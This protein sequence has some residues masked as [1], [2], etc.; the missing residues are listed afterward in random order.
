MK[1]SLFKILFFVSL[2]F[3]F[4]NSQMQMMPVPD[5]DAEIDPANLTPDPF[6]L[7]QFKKFVD[8]IVL[9]LTPKS[10]NEVMLNFPHLVILFQVS[11]NPEIFEGYEK[12]AKH[13]KKKYKVI[14]AVYTMTSE[15]DEIVQKFH[16]KEYPQIYF[17]DKTKKY[18]YSGD[19]KNLTEIRSFIADF[20]YREIIELKTQSDFLSFQNKPNKTK[21]LAVYEPKM[22]KEKKLLAEM[23]S[24]DLF[25][26][27]GPFIIGWTTDQSIIPYPSNVE[28]PSL[29]LYNNFTD[30]EG[31]KIAKYEGDYYDGQEI[32]AF[33]EL[34][35]LP[36]VSIYN[37][38]NS[39]RIFAGPVDVQILL[40]LNKE[41]DHSKEIEE[42]K[43][44][45]RYNKEEE[46]HFER[47]IFTI[48]YFEEE[49]LDFLDFFGIEKSEDLATSKIF[50]TK[51]D[52]QL[53]RMD[54][55]LFEKDEIIQENLKDFIEDFRTKQVKRFYKSDP[56]VDN[57]NNWPLILV[58]SEFVKEVIRSRDNYVVLFCSE[59]EKKQCKGA[60][61]FFEKLAERITLE[62]RNKVKFAYFDMGRNEVC[63]K[64]Y[65]EKLIFSNRQMD[66]KSKVFHI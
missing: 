8:P 6:K 11:Q 17:V 23:L 37:E 31:G 9:H 29:I 49:H 22:E 48:V 39:F 24:K 47:I 60:R 10:F 66:W 15:I 26:D 53:Q 35:S 13:I 57:T 63:F 62:D 25:A 56:V 1:M 4:T 36:L 30:E 59:F 50:L 2:L 5:S 54:K 64:F 3:F 12:L 34:N 14:F 7:P 52:N 21:L 16:I 28:L 51:I 40:I 18:A 65:M 20:L 38:E 27:S 32:M 19:L 55:Y 43:K 44:A 41:G 42:F 45:A 61:K 58:G 33:C 46:L